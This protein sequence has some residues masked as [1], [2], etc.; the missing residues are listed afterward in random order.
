MLVSVWHMLTAHQPYEELGAD[1]F[2]RINPGLTRRRALAQLANLGFEVT[3]TP[4]CLTAPNNTRRP[5]RNVKLPPGALCLARTRVATT[6]TAPPAGPFTR[7][8]PAP[9]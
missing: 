3:L 2:S 8:S 1:Y 9:R 7:Q 4:H 6:P 5:R